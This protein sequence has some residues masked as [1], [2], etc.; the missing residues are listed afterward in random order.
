MMKC[1]LA[2]LLC[3]S[4][5]AF[6]KASGQRISLE[7][8]FTIEKAF[9]SIEKQS[10]YSFFYDYDLL[11]QAKPVRVSIRNA[12]LEDALQAVLKDQPFTYA[13][14]NKIIV[15]QPK[16]LQ[17]NNIPASTPRVP[18]VEIKGKISN[19]EGE[20]L[21]GAVVNLKGTGKTAVTD[22]RGAFTL[23]VDPAE[24]TLGTLVVTHVGHLRKEVRINKRTELQ[25]SMEKNI[26]QMKDVVVTSGYARPKRKEE[27]VGSISTVTSKE[28]QTQRPIESFDKMLEGLAAGVQV[29]TNTE[30]GTPVKINIRGQNSLTNLYSSRVAATSSQPLFVVDGVPVVEQRRGDEPIAFINNE[31]LLNPLAGINPS[32]IE[33]VSILKDAAATSIYG[34][35]ASNG[36]VIITTKKG[37]TGKTRI[38]VGYSYGWSQPINQIQWLTGSQ[39]HDL[40]KEL[41]INI[42]RDPY[43][44]DLLAG[45]SD[46]NT[47]WFGLTN[48]YG[49]YHNIDFDMS[50]GNEGT[51]FRISGQV[52]DQESIQKGNDYKKASFNLRL[53]HVL[54]PRL[55]LTATLAPTFVQKN[56][57]NVY[58]NVPIIPNV[59]SY[60]AD[61]SFYQLSSLLVPNPLAVLAQ[62]V[63]YHGGG[64]LNGSLRLNLQATKHLTL[65]TNFGISGLIN[66]QN[67]FQ[68]GQN[69]TGATKGG[70]AE[71]YDRTNFS[72]VSFSQASW[73]QRINEKHGI[74]ITAGFEAQSQNTKLLRGGGSGFTYYRLNELSNA[75][76]QFAA[77]SKQVSNSYSVYGQAAYDFDTRY[78]L[79][80]SGR[81]DAASIFGP[82]VNAT[83]NTAIGAGWNI[84]REKFL[85]K[86]AFIDLLR[87][88]VSYGSTG[89]SRIGS[90][91]AKGIYSFNN[92]GY[93]G[94][95][96]SNP[97]SAP[98]ADLGWEKGY[99]FN[100]GIDFSFLK[101]FN[102]TLDVYNN[103]TDDAISSIRVPVV[104]GFTTTLANIA[105]MR[106]RGFDASLSAQIF[107]KKFTWTSTL[108][109]GYNKNVI[110]DVKNNEALYSSNDLAS[111]LREG[112]STTA[113]W[114][115][116]Y[117]GVD[118]QTGD[119]LYVTNKGAVVPI[120][121][122]D[123]SIQNSYII[124]DR[125]PKLQGGFINAF[126][127]KGVSLNIILTYSLGGKD[128]ID[129]N[130]EADGN[131]L[132][133]RNASVNL[134]GRWQKPGD[135]TNVPKLRQLPV[136]VV[137]STRYLYNASFIKISNVSLSYTVPAI[138][139]LKG[140]RTQVFANATNLAYWYKE[141]SPE[142]RNGYREYRF[143]AFPEAQTFNW[144]IRFGF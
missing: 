10:G 94:Y 136:P 69:A 39:Y 143:G 85:L 42:G 84:S 70:F 58:S 24:A 54:S 142:G 2:L 46:I 134:L 131:N 96:S 126:S 132:T 64:T 41:Y 21:S 113:I 17:P 92:T 26:Q 68:S 99:K 18:P 23:T 140:L 79:N 105:K 108:N 59:P 43:S 34:A 67:I 25:V 128:L 133:N 121:Q 55:N 53:D 40:V 72:W 37:R 89:N 7:G 29:Q 91:Q 123:R 100:A 56:A 75:Q 15:L 81:Y 8:E 52:Q 28:L 119:P 114:G 36:V 111:A 32:D 5:Q 44:A 11:K 138:N 80:V 127:Y 45:P 97:S 65:S 129:Y 47:N 115:F 104:N 130:L 16:P 76:S 125:L 6:T 27:V 77:S 73:R 51:Q 20:A 12:T 87:L 83:V 31:Q 95:T 30:L 122:L 118:P 49:N 48:R 120:Q 82:D 61:G 22:E 35:N 112:Y 144:G 57:L 9:S 124:G 66:K 137:N 63:D 98:N 50:G 78:F 110:L 88:R 116:E 109:A 38:N 102:F 90:Y 106:N 74:D 103:I 93:N 86:A 1:I 13:I 101:R 33:S 139:R 141:K 19:E 62:N 14:Q 3:F 135:V 117:A 107:N 71:I 60:N 4:L